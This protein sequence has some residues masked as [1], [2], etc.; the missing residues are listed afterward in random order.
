MDKHYKT[1]RKQAGL[2]RTLCGML[3]SLQAITGASVA[4]T[5]PQ[6]EAE[7]LSQ[8]V[9]STPPPAPPGSV[10][11]PPL[12]EDQQPPS[13]TVMPM[14][15]KI[16]IKLMNA[17]NAVVTYQ[18]IGDTEPR[19][20]KGDSDVTLQN[21]ET[22]VT[23][24]FEREDKGFVKVSPQATSEGLLQVTLDEAMNVDE[25]KG[26]MNVQEDGQVFVN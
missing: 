17:T 2:F 8:S 22:P 16:N 24:T 19:F 6:M 3:I 4:S 12:P 21:L 11:Q 7:P 5:T 10:I 18:V 20:L 25:G 9:P 23:V 1:S 14:D 26:T 13:A 15:G